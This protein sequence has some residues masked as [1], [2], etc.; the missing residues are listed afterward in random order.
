MQV[1]ILIFLIFVFIV[2]LY[3]LYKNKWINKLL[4]ILIIIATFLWYFLPAILTISGANFVV[5]FNRNNIEDLYGLMIKEFVFFQIILFFFWL[6]ENKVKIKFTPFILVENVNTRRNQNYLF[7]V[8]LIVICYYIFYMFQYKMD[9]EKN[10]DISQQQGGLFQIVSLVSN[11]FVSFLWVYYIFEKERTKVKYYLCIFLISGFS[12][13]MVLSGSRIYV[14]NFIFLFVFSLN[15]TI[16][17]WKKFKYVTAMLIVIGV[18]LLLL[19]IL[20]NKRAGREEIKLSNSL[21]LVPQE[22]NIKLNSFS[23]SEVLI[24]YDGAEFAGFNPYIGS[25][26]KFVPRFLWNNKP[27]ATSFNNDVSGIPSRRIPY[28]Q[29]DKSESYNV[30]TSAFAVSLWQMGY[31]TVFLAIILNVFFLKVLNRMLNKKS[32]I[33]KSIAFMML[34]FPQLVM[35]PTFG[36]NIIQVLELSIVITI[37]FLVLG[38]LKLVKSENSII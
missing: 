28:L 23:Y 34:T 20:A 27:T 15:K 3:L 24:K 33:I 38:F 21:E 35:F 36:D 17:N 2:E 8:S 13:T 30:G 16:S 18:S 25:V 22:L 31:L 5:F 12:I 7:I 32:F 1:S 14:L 19:P 26:F 9:Y 37:V 10:N 4:S 29:G 6:L 11:F